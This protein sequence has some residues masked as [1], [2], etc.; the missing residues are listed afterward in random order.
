MALSVREERKCSFSNWAHYHPQLQVA[1]GR[2]EAVGNEYWVGKPVDSPET[3][4]WEEEGLRILLRNYG[5]TQTLRSETVA[6]ISSL[7]AVSLALTHPMSFSCFPS[8][9]HLSPSLLLQGLQGPYKIFFLYSIAHQFPGVCLEAVA[10][11]RPHQ[12]GSQ[13]AGQLVIRKG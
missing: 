2:K 3:G 4:A 10:V 1:A 7:L 12:H 13:E 9:A 5:N 8:L 6:F 11:W